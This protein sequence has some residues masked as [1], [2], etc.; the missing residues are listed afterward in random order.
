METIQSDVQ[1]ELKP[2]LI[3]LNQVG[4]SD[5]QISLD[6]NGLFVP[7]KLSV[8]V[9]LKAGNRGI[10]MSRLY[11]I[12]LKYLNG[13][14]FKD[15]QW[16]ELLKRLVDSQ[17][18]LSQSAFIEM[19]YQLPLKRTSLKSNL[20]GHR[21]YSLKSKFLYD[22]KRIENSAIHQQDF[23]I[24]YS[25]TCPQ[26][27]SLAKELTKNFFAGRPDED[28]LQWMQS[29]KYF[30]ATPHAQRSRMKI[31]LQSIANQVLDIEPWINWFEHALQTPV[32]T[33]VKKADE[34]EFAR[35]N[36]E[37]P[38]FCEDALR[39]V[40]RVIASETPK[41]KNLIAYKVETSHEESLHSH[42]AA[43]LMK[44]QNFF[45]F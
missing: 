2:D 32:Q 35:L 22:Q 44:S 11:E 20:Q 29:D 8:F 17:K 24:L 39:I 41:N 4:M 31:S 13:H 12:I 10:H 3:E 43:G 26:S 30:I 23:E 37:N 14:S 28:V 38:M 25:S 15:F 36:A 7:V 27:T 5:V 45:H 16:I 19:D 1:S 18:G 9:D 34:M 33:A 21:N 42:N 6:I 40:S